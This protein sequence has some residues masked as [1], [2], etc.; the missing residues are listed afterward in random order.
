MY[1]GVALLDYANLPK[2]E[3][4]FLQVLETMTQAE[5]SRG[6]S[7]EHLIARLVMGL[8]SEDVD[9]ASCRARRVMGLMLEVKE[10][11]STACRL[12]REQLWKTVSLSW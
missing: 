8:I 5:L 7:P 9:T 6:L 10:L 4:L 11:D 2:M 12:V 1:F 3:Q